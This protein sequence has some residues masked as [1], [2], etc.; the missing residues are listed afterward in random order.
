MDT[1][2]ITGDLAKYAASA[3][4]HDASLL[5]AKKAGVAVAAGV[6]GAADRALSYSRRTKAVPWGGQGRRQDEE[7]GQKVG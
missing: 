6:A 3:L 1:A 5:Q 4:P 7:E 2:L